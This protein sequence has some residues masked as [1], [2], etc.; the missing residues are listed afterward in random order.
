MKTKTLK[1]ILGSEILLLLIG[2]VALIF[3]F[4]KDSQSIDITNTAS[5]RDSILVEPP[6]PET[7]DELIALRYPN[8]KNWTRNPGP[9]KVGLQIGHWKNE[10][11][12]DE[13]YKLRGTSLGAEAG[14]YI[15]WEVTSTIVHRVRSLLNSHGIEVDIFPA[16][17]PQSYEADLFLSFHADGSENTSERGFKASGF[18]YDAT[19]KNEDFLRAFYKQ[20]PK[21][22][23][24]PSDDRVSINM[25]G[26]Y[27]FN[28]I[29]Y[30]HTIHPM[31]PGIILELGFLSNPFDRNYLTQHPDNVAEGV[32]NSVLQYFDII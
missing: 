9:L 12:P 29:Y 7:F 18:W 25:L 30:E 20:Y 8:L 27:A 21:V 3:V 26:Y 13:L 1:Y 11:L 10:E 4:T 17:I 16:T 23:Q 28:W 24:L 32:A 22:T 14:G 2:F 19:G 31:T 15:E 6:R 5:L